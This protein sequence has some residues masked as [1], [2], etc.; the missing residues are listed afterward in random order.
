MARRALIRLLRVLATIAI[1]AVTAWC[2]S[3]LA[4]S[5]L[6][7]R[8]AAVVMIA[9]G[10]SAALATLFG[11]QLFIA[12]PLFALAVGAFAVAWSTVKPSNDRDWQPDVAVVPYATFD[13][14]LVTIHNIRNFEYRTETDFTP[15]YYDKTYDLRDLDT[16]DLIACYWMGDAIAHVMISFGFAER[17]FVAVS[18]E[19]RKE[20]GESY[21]TVNGFFRQYELTYIVGDERDLIRLR[22]NYRKDPPEEVYLFRTNAPKENVRRLFLDYFKTINSLRDKPQFYNT[23][24]TNCTTNVVMHTKVNPG[25]GHYSWKVLLSG[26]APQYAYDRGRLDASI[27]FAE[28]KQRSHINEAAHAADQDPNFSQKI[29]AGLPRP[30]AATK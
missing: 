12:L 15:R 20:K 18:I 29:R 5:P 7:A 19:T 11:R 28:L 2:A 17:D 22:T 13:G 25:G 1:L 24:T 4:L 10:V 9:C 3:A 27:P 30:P 23:L 14:D 16:A 8:A 6:Q 21:S 26:Y